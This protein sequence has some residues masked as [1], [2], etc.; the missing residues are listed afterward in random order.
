VLFALRSLV[1][2]SGFSLTCRKTVGLGGYGALCFYHGGCRADCFLED[3]GCTVRFRPKQNALLGISIG[4]V[5]ALGAN[6]PIGLGVEKKPGSLR[7]SPDATS[8]A[9]VLETFLRSFESGDLIPQKRS[10]TSCS[11]DLNLIESRSEV[12][13]HRKTSEFLRKL[14]AKD[15]LDW[16]LGLRVL[17]GAGSG[18]NGITADGSTIQKSWSRHLYRISP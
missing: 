14:I 10:G 5:F 13:D 1:A 17:S 4:H 12:V 2:V 7:F 11:L 18:S 3:L 8:F 15:C 16:M 9:V 6:V